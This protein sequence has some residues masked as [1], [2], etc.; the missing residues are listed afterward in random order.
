MNKLLLIICFCIGGFASANPVYKLKSPDNKLEVAI[1]IKNG[2]HYSVALN[3]RSML[4][5]ADIDLLFN[6]KPLAKGAKLSKVTTTTNK[7]LV[8]PVIPL[9]N[10]VLENHYNQLSLFFKNNLTVEFRAYDNGVSYR[11]V[12]NKNDSVKVNETNNL[13]FADDVKMWVSQVDG[14]AC[15]YEKPYLQTTIS[16]FS[17]TL[18]TY[19]PL[20]IEQRDGYKMLITEA[21]LYDYPHMFFKKADG[22]RLTATFPPSPLKTEIIGDRQSKIT[23]SADYIAKTTGK[24]SFPWRVL[25]IT[26]KDAQLIE[27]NL[28]YLLS[29]D[30]KLENTAW[31]K[32]GRTTWEWW[33]ATNL[34]GVNFKAGLNT[35]TYK[36]YIDFASKNGLEYLI[37]DEGWSAS[38]MDLSHPNPSIDLKE[39]IRYG[40]EKNVRIILW[41]TW[42]AVNKQISILDTF[43]EWGIAGIKIDYMNRADQ[44]MVNFYEKIARE[45]AKRQ[46]LVDFHGAFKPTGLQRAYPNVLSYEGV[47]GLEQCKVAKTVTP[48]HNLTLPF[49]RMVCGPMDYTPGAMR[50]YHPKEFQP[51]F[52]HPGSQ[53]TRCHQLAL[54]IVFESGIQMLCDSPSNYEREQES[55]NFLSS[56]PVTWDETR[57]L[58]AKVSQYLVIARRKNDKWFIGALNNGIEREFKIDLSFLSSG[59]KKA[60]ILQDG[61]NSNNFAEDYNHTVKPLTNQSE[62]TIRMVS[63]GGFVARIE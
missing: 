8:T 31:I 18:N 58:E 38:T 39:L 46:L 2:I 37:M 44:W 33:N 63:D 24:R 29:K 23:Q 28:V 59:T 21:D 4:K 43:K 36:Y 48:E 62:L 1:D 41:A 50:N 22:N 10:S 54:S 3:G 35:D 53:G 42:C 12:T 25:I 47:H 15:S 19:L 57:V 27:S 34:Y 17:T 56:V 49:I 13:E 5:N 32:P 51:N 52:N 11:F 7:N 40:K 14:Y 6:G 60:T 30:N 45:A 20:L 26:E 61:I 9:K 55:T 16:D